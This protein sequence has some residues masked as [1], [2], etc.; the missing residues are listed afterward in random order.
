MIQVLFLILIWVL[1]AL[2]MMN[3]YVKMNESEKQS[4][5]SELKQPIAFFTV[6]FSLFGLLISL[7]GIILAIKWMQHLGVIMVFVSWFTISIVSWKRGKIKLYTSTMLLLL[8]LIGVS[9]YCY[10]FMI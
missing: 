4:F 10:C 7:S 9:I 6:G 1:P 5:K 8:G 2:L 3:T